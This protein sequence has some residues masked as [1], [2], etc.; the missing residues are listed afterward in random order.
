MIPDGAV[1][2]VQRWV[3]ERIPDHVRDHVRIELDV[4]NRTITILDRPRGTPS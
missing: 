4:T 1:Q 3:D 2:G